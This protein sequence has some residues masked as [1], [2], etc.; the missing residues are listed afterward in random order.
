MYIKRTVLD[1]ATLSKFEFI[2][3]LTDVDATGWRDVRTLPRRA[4]RDEVK[5]LPTGIEFIKEFLGNHK[6]YVMD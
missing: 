1:R 5:T 2:I 6:A 4:L 3:N